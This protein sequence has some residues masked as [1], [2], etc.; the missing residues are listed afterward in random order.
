MASSNQWTFHGEES[1]SL[2]LAK[3]GYDVWIGNNRGNYYSLEHETLDHSID[4]EEYWDFTW[5]EMGKYDVPAQIDK[6]L[7]VTGK[8]KLTYIGFSTGC[9]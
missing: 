6:I 5:T 4:H 1:P 2:L 7:S 9:T 3:Q 8:E